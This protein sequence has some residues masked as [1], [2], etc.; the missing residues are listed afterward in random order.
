[1]SAK[2]E[3]PERVMAFIAKHGGWSNALD[4]AER[5]EALA[6]SAQAAYERGKADAV[7]TGCAIVPREMHL[8]PE[9][10]ECIWIMCGYDKDE[11]EADDKWCGGTLWVGDIEDDE[12]NKTHGLHIANADYPEEG[13]VTLVELQSPKPTHQPPS[14]EGNGDA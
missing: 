8:T 7:P 6:E 4:Y 12:G 1:M 13:S 5:L 9:A 10:L 2:P 11:A 14:S 3:L